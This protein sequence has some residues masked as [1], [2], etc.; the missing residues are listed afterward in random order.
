MRCL[1]FS[2]HGFLVPRS[3]VR[4][5]V[6]RGS[7]VVGLALGCAPPSAGPAINAHSLTQPLEGPCPT[8]QGGAEFASEVTSLAATI[9]GPGI[10]GVLSGEGTTSIT[11]PDVPAG[12]DRVIALFGLQNGAPTWRGV[13]R[14]TATTAGVDTPVD[15]LLAKVA[16]FSCARNTS[17]EKRVFH[18][19]TL[20]DDGTVL[21]VGGARSF[22]DAQETCGQGCKDA[23][24]TS[25]AAL[26]NPGTGQFSEVGPLLNPRMFH[27]AVKLADG[28]V[29]VVG[30]TGR[31]IFRAVDP[32]QSPFPIDP[33][34][35]LASVEVYDPQQKAFV[36]GGVDPGGP[37][38]FA[39]ATTLLT[40]EA[41]I[42]GGI[43]G[44]SARIDLSDALATTTICGGATF[45]CQAGPPMAVAR[46]GHMAFTIEPDGV[47]LWGG[48]IDV[49]N[50]GLGNGFQIEQ[51]E[52]GSPSS[53]LLNACFM[54]ADRNVFFAAG[55]LY[56]GLR[57][58]AAGGLK[59]E[60]DGTFHSVLDGDLEGSAVFVYDL[61]IAGGVDNPCQSGVTA[62]PSG[63]RMNLQGSRFLASAAGLPDRA[64]ALIVGGF[65]LPT[66]FNDVSFAP[67]NTIDLFIEDGLIIDDLSAGGVVP[68]L[69]DARGGATATAIGDGTVV[70]VGGS[71][72]D[73][74]LETAEVFADRKVP[75][76]AAGLVSP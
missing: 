31:A 22:Q 71:G 33:I 18:T 41:I 40:G 16:D 58:L 7:L 53:A 19:S 1:R 24:A 69:H 2:L 34:E 27:T 9:V 8:T 29:V 20:L 26:Y 25:S 10:E 68:T 15:V 17:F 65:T 56:S 63:A 46:A 60:N 3:V 42:T 47:F 45:I 72:D 64:S 76:H 4:G 61:A 74:P 73:G 23:R 38:V 57:M 62:G 39:A 32:G 12:V 67:V 52:P 5:S 54:N 50:G 28:R 44:S 37:R 75:P 6:V 55:S 14:P 30:G 70:I 36:S 66:D 35:P 48:S 49:D 11:I 21:V 59:R 51:L 43:D 13:S